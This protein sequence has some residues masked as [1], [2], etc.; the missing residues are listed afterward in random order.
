LSQAGVA[1]DV[2]VVQIATSSYGRE[3]H[4]MHKINTTTLLFAT[5]STTHFM[6][7]TPR[8]IFFVMQ[9]IGNNYLPSSIMLIQLSC[10]TFPSDHIPFVLRP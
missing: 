6:I 7:D 3:P 4:N 5:V 8:K 10:T 9:N 2:E 1:A